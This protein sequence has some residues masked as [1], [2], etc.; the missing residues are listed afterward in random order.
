MNFA[1]I[2]FIFAG[3]IVLFV[4]RCFLKGF[5]NEFLSMAAILLGVLAAVFFYKD[6]GEF[7][8]ERFMPGMDVLPDILAFIALLL[9]VALVVNLLKL[10]ISGI[11]AGVKLGGADRFL[12]IVFGFAEGI[13]VISLILF[14]LTLIQPVIDTNQLLADSFFAGLL[15]PFITGRENIPF[16]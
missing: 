14:V 9:I 2:D 8:R 5:V 11:I 10:M 12:G 13:A 3:L 16:V 1:V 4:I 15:L 6:V 7:F